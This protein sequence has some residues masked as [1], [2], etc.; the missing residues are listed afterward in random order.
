MWNTNLKKL[1]QN[2]CNFFFSNVTFT[3]LVQ[4]NLCTWAR[5]CWFHKNVS[6]PAAF[7]IQ[8]SCQSVTKLISSTVAKAVSLVNNDKTKTVRTVPHH[9]KEFWVCLG[10]FFGYVL[11]LIIFKEH[12]FS[13]CACLQIGTSLYDE[14]GAG[15]VKDLMAKAEKNKVRIT[16]PVDFVTADKFDENATTG[17][18][19]VAAGIPAGWMVRQRFGHLDVGLVLS[20]FSWT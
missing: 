7:K 11:R 16:L 2:Y 18:A 19:T 17:T 10:F 15:I 8:S 6:T 13:E 5:S 4:T 9:K 3:Y 1:I 14:E 12:D 20:F